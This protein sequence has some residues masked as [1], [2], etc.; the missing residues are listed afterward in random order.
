MGTPCLHVCA[1]VCAQEFDLRVERLLVLL[2]YAASAPHLAAFLAANGYLESILKDS[3][4]PAVRCASTQTAV[5]L[6]PVLAGITHCM[7]GAAPVYH[8]SCGT[9]VLPAQTLVIAAQCLWLGSHQPPAVCL[10]HLQTS[11]ARRLHWASCVCW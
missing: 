2:S 10:I 7:A 8:C 3:I 11:R 6:T 4:V 9:A 5:P 1:H